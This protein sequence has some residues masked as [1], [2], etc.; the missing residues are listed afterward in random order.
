MEGTWL[1]QTGSLLYGPHN[2]D[3]EDPSLVHFVGV[4][5]IWHFIGISVFMMAVFILMRLIVRRA[6]RYN[7]QPNGS[8]IQSELEEKEMLITTETETT[9]KGEMMDLHCHDKTNV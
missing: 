2:W 5:A 3:V 8:D 9:K 1:V 7:V 4:I 6:N